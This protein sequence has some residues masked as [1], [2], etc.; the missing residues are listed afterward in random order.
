MVIQ[1]VLG[2]V[3]FSKDVVFKIVSKTVLGTEGLFE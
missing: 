3:T 1:N 2:H